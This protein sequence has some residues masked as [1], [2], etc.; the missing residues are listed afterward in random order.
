MKMKYNQEGY[1]FQFSC[2]SY[3][4]LW[5]PLLICRSPWQSVIE[6]LELND[7]FFFSISLKGHSDECCFERGRTSLASWQTLSSRD[8]CDAWL[9]LLSE[10]VAQPALRCQVGGGAGIWKKDGGLD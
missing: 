1:P 8:P 5:S 6:L 3:S 10:R 7:L 9:G 2:I 4:S